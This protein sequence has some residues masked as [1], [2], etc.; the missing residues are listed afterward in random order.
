MTPFN[1]F[2]AREPS[3]VRPIPRASI[4][5]HY[6]GRRIRIHEDEQGTFWLVLVDLFTALQRTRTWPMRKRVRAAGQ[7]KNVCAWIPNTVN[8]EASG[9]R[10]VQ[11][12]NTEGLQAMLGLSGSAQAH[13]LLLWLTEDALPGLRGAA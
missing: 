6:L 12:T 4:K 7:V 11:A 3:A 2:D 9:Y 5:V 1:S 13:D 8:P 10:M